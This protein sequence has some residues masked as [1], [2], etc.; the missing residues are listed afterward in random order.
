VRTTI[1]QIFGAALFAQRLQL[2][3][4]EP[5]IIRITGDPNTPVSMERADGVKDYV[6][7]AGRG[8]IHHL[9][10]GDWSYA[11]G[12]RKAAVPL[13][14]HPDTNIIWG[15]NG[16]MALGALRAVRARQA[17]VLVGGIGGFWDATDSPSASRLARHS[18]TDGLS[19]RRSV[20]V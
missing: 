4:Q 8:R 1:L 15:A 13:S 10:F 9:A 11:D 3:N 7:D 12:E 16:S 17:R 5:R 18:I 20:I 14:R 6:A 19:E 2:G